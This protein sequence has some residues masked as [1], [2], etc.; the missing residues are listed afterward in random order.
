MALSELEAES[1][2]TATAEDLRAQ[3]GAI[4]DFIL[5]HLSDEGLKR[6]FLSLSDVQKVRTHS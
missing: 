4:V 3:A 1:G 6:A 5:Q 2:N